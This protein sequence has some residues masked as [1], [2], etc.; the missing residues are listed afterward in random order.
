MPNTYAGT[1]SPTNVS[2][3][4]GKIFFNRQD[5]NGVLQG[6]VHLGNCDNLSVS[7]GVETKEMV[8]FMTNT[9]APY[10]RVVTKTTVEA[11]ISG[12]EFHPDVAALNVLGDVV[13]VTQSTATVTAEALAAAA[14]TKKGKTFRTLKRNIS[15]VA[16]KQGATTLTLGTDYTIA[17]ATMGLVS[18]PATSA[19]DDALA[20]TVD[21]TAAAIIAG[22][23]VKRVR[24]A[25]NSRIEGQLAFSPDPA[26]GPSYEALYWRVQLA[27]SGE[28][29][30]ISEDFNKWEMTG[31]VQDDSAGAYGG[32][33]TSPYGDLIAR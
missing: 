24:V 7:T 2:L 19:V 21:Y 30:L 26:A 28:F 1:P 22:D 20:V 23:G 29:G 16:V 32:S 25:T 13:P 6:F 14:V 8:N 31:A 9:S 12:F 27:P 18:F 5:A 15:A 11:K 33:S 10:K 17:D 3:G 4:R